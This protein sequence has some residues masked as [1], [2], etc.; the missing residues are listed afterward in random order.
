MVAFTP[1]DSKLSV[2]VLSS[3]SAIQLL[4]P[5]GPFASEVLTLDRFSPLGRSFAILRTD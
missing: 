3:D 2:L 4:W 5:F 1:G